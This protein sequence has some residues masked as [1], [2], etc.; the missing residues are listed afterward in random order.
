MNCHLTQHISL[1]INNNLEEGTIFLRNLNCIRYQLEIK[2]ASH[3]LANVITSGQPYEKSG[4]LRL[5]SPEDVN[6]ISI[7]H[8]QSAVVSVCGS[9]AFGLGTEGM[10]D[11]YRDETTLIASLYW[12]G[13]WKQIG[14]ELHLTNLDNERYL[15]EVS[16]PP[17]EGILGDLAVDIRDAVVDNPLQ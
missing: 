2:W 12:N 10:I 13:P 1:T 11:L 7:P 15:A 3:H 17:F 9:A 6:Q 5:I 8:G 14:N 4:T 16:T